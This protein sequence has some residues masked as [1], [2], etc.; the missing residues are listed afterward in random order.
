VRKLLTYLFL[1]ICLLPI[2]L[3]IGYSISYSLGL[4]GLLSEGFTWAHWRTFFTSG[5]LLS[6]TL[7]TL[8]LGV[9]S[10][11]IAVAAG[12]V[13]SW[14]GGRYD[15]GLSQSHGSSLSELG[16]LVPLLFAP[17][18]AAFCW[19]QI[20]SPGGFIARLSYHLGLITDTTDFPR[21]VN[22]EWGIGIVICHVFLILPVF[23]YLFTATARKHDLAA[24]YQQSRSLGS[25]SVHF[26]R[27][28]YAPIVLFKNSRVLWLYLI[29]LLGTYE[30]PLLL[31]SSSPQTFSV[32][33]ADKLTKFN[34]AD[35]PAGHCMAI[36]YTLLITVMT[37]LYL[38]WQ[39][40]VIW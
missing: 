32:F 18:T 39:R 17:V 33:I 28:V 36:W 7:Y 11:L 4:T 37:L 13:V 6:S 15:K 9:V 16:I 40:R 14:T 24:L 5:N 31:G 34:L 26:F 3:G 1:C 27:T 12:L 2:L 23:T 29:F 25:G 20:L 35:I 30:V 19:Y 38:R 21:I 22:D 8:G 10:L